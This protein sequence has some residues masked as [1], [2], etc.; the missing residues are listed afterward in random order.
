[1]KQMISFEF[2]RGIRSL[3]CRIS[4]LFACLFM[5]WQNIYPTLY[6]RYHMSK[7]GMYIT[8]TGKNIY[9]T[10]WYP[11]SNVSESMFYYFYFYGLLV[12][13]PFGVSYFLD[14]KKGY[15]KNI[16]N[17]TSRSKYLISKYI[18]VFLTG[19]IVSSVP[20]ILDFLVFRLIQPYDSIDLGVACVLSGRTT[21]EIFIIDHM[22]LGA[23]AIFLVWFVF[24]GA[25]ATLSL[26]ASTFSQNVFFIQLFPFF[27]MM[28]V[29]Y[30]PQLSKTG[31]GY[32]PVNFLRV[33]SKGIPT[34]AFMVSLCIVCITFVLFFFRE[35]KRDVL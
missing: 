25:L 10:R 26:F 1:M 23:I 15:I 4:F 35:R 3:G 13:L 33:S 11:A 7:I 31:S 21:W 30:L 29:Y 19:G 12:A 16:C 22:Y 24:G 8:K 6:S 2:K 27:S 18:A 9:S 14:R 17:R 5:I 20:V 28:L 32:L 34:K